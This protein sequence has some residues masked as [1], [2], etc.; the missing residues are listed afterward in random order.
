MIKFYFL[1]NLPLLVDT[2][3]FFVCDIGCEFLCVGFFVC[4]IEVLKSLS[5]HV[6]IKKKHCEKRVLS[7]WRE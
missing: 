4:L 6:H 3:L 5:K 7:N 2:A 1:L